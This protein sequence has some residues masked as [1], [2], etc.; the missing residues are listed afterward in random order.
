M[1]KDVAGRSD[2]QNTGM[3]DA[4]IL[5]LDANGELTWQNTYGGDDWDEAKSIYQTSDGG[6]IA[7]GVTNSLGAEWDA[8]AFK[9]APDGMLQWQHHFGGTGSD[10]AHD[11]CQTSDNSYM[12]AGVTYSFGSGGDVYLLRLGEDGNLRWVKTYGGSTLDEANSICHTFDDGYIIAGR[13]D[14]FGAGLD[15]FY[16]MKID[17]DGNIEHIDSINKHMQE[18]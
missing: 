3:Y 5:K 4:Y 15:D 9:I 11:V 2:S 7:V 17:E 18:K 12:I 6:Y 14:S 1:A 16:I 13:T 8:Y 10:E